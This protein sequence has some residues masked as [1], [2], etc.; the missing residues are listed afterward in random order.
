MQSL[1]ASA[2]SL[3]L[4]GTDAQPQQVYFLGKPSCVGKCSVVIGFEIEFPVPRAENTGAAEPSDIRE[5]IEMMQ[6]D[7]ECLHPTHRKP[8]HRPMP[9]IR[10]C[11]ECRI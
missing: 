1:Q 3:G 11:P 8:R 5:E 4:F 10:N 9:T 2:H 7:A 6:R